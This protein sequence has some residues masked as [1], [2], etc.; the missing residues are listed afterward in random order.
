VLVLGAKRFR[1]E[2]ENDSAVPLE[3]D[4]HAFSCCAAPGMGMEIWFRHSSAMASNRPFGNHDERRI[5]NALSGI[6]PATAGSFS[7]LSW[8]AA[9]TSP[10][11]LAGFVISSCAS[12][13]SMAIA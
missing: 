4:P 11:R 3:A 1:I 7:P 2:D 13:S 10:G 6:V 8:T 12:S 9:S 5:Q